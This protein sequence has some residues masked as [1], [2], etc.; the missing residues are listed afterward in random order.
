MGTYFGILRMFKPTKTKRSGRRA[1]GAKCQCCGKRHGDGAPW[2]YE[3][4]KGWFLSKPR[5]LLAKGQSVHDRAAHDAA[6]AKWEAGDIPSEKALTPEF[7]VVTGDGEDL[8]VETLCEAYL[9]YLERTAAP[10]TFRQCKDLFEDLCRHKTHG[11]GDVTVAQMRVD[12]ISRIKQ[13]AKTPHYHKKTKERTAGLNGSLATVYARIKAMF[14]YAA[15]TSDNE[16]SP[17]LI[18][19]NPVAKLNTGKNRVKHRRRQAM[20]TPA[21]VGAVLAYSEK[22]KRCRE[23]GLAFKVLIA[24]G[25]RPEEFCS[26]TAADVKFDDNGSMYWLVNHKKQKITGERRR[27]YLLSQEM[28]DITKQQM[29]KHPEGPLFRN[30]WEQRWTG[31]ALLNQFRTITATPECKKLGLDECVVSNEAEIAKAKKLGVDL[32]KARHEHKYVIYTTRHTFG[33]RWVNGFYGEELSYQRV[34]DLMGN[35]AAEVEKTYGHVKE[36]TPGFVS[37]LL[38]KNTKTETAAA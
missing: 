1:H 30:G 32:P 35:S 20:F 11:I 18:A 2:W 22:S 28:V 29:D 14:N 15:D 6:M 24:T 23:F 4:K 26:V 37:R 27:V 19:S 12:G 17:R 21:Q 8:T 3:A 5:R 9:S 13:W 36:G 33:Y 25:C 38:A 34:A 10:K 31:G 16:E 7:T